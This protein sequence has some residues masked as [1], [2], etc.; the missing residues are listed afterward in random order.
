MNVTQF[1]GVAHVDINAQSG[2]TDM[3]ESE[4]EIM[5]LVALPGISSVDR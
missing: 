5:F 3:V 1:V 4:D 2:I